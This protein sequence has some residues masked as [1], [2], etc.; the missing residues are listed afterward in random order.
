VLPIILELLGWG[1]G[2][3]LGWLIGLLG[4]SGGFPGLL[5]LQL[6]IVSTA[7]TG[8]ILTME[9]KNAR[10]RLILFIILL[11]KLVIFLKIY[12]VDD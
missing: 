12:G 11:A 10:I 1:W 3:G 9:G 8:K 4:C 2:W 5:P 6:K 7:K